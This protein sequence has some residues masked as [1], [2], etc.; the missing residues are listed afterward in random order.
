MQKAS[1]VFIQTYLF[2][3]EKQLIKNCQKGDKQSQYLLVKRYSNMLYKVCLRYARD[4]A[5]AKDVLQETFI[6]IF[7]SINKYVDK[8]AFE[9]W[10]RQIAIRRSLQWLE[11]SYFQK[12]SHLSILPDDRKIEPAIYEKFNLEEIKAM[13]EELPLGFKV[14]F[15]L[16]V[17]EGYTHKEI[18]SML[19]ITESTSRSH[20]T[21]ARKILQE[22]IINQKKTSRYELGMVR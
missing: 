19:D 9:A 11:K 14:V 6:R 1:G 17:L 5:M 8:G 7:R 21:R 13:V 4:E 10:M 2:V 18:A 20:L 22:K 3:T 15:N 16:N 12:E